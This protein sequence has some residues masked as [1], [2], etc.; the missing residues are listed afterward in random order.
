MRRPALVTQTGLRLLPESLVRVLDD[1]L[2]V[3]A[4]DQARDVRRGDRD[5][6]V[7]VRLVGGS[8]NVT[9]PAVET[10][11]GDHVARRLDRG[12][13]LDRETHDL[14]EALE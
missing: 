1:R 8:Q 14:I 4:V 12:A 9:G 6:T 5:L 3:L 10:V 11:D 2:G 7:R 13:S